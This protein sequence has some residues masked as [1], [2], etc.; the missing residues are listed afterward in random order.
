[1]PSVTQAIFV[2]SFVTTFV[3]L[4]FISS[5]ISAVVTAHGYRPGDLILIGLE[6][7]N[8]T[9]GAPPTMLTASQI[10]TTIKADPSAQAAVAAGVVSVILL[11]SSILRSSKPSTFCHT[12]SIL[13]TNGLCFAEKK[14][15]LNPQEW[16]EFPLTSKFTVSPNTALYAFLFFSDKCVFSTHIATA[17]RYQIQ[18]MFLGYR[19]VST[20]LFKPRSTESRYSVPIRRRVAM[21]TSATSICSLRFASRLLAEYV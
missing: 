13:F 10:W 6:K 12:I 18:M 19:S 7:K 21:M 17:S 15:V 4:Y 3:V 14:S 2:G 16:Q 8:L 5:Y 20:Y 11:V 9:E 1:M